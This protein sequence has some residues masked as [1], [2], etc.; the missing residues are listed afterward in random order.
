[1]PSC[2]K[3][4]LTPLALAIWIMDDGSKMGK[5][6]KLCTNCFI[7]SDCLLLVNCLYEKF[8]IKATIQ[9]AGAKSKDQYHIYIRVESMTNL[10]SI[11]SPYIIPEMMYKIT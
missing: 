3:V 1:V 9:L 8:S 7:Y 10:R 4:Y 11:V 5:S 6:L 2:I